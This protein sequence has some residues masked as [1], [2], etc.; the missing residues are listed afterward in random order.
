MIKLKSLCKNK[1]EIFDINKIK[2]KNFLLIFFDI[3]SYNAINKIKEIKNYIIKN[4][5]NIL[6]LH[7][8]N[9]FIK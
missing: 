4:N 5:K 8:I 2:N 7:I 1:Y 3:L 6:F 9:M